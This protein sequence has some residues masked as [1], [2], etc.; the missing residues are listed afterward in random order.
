M[1]QWPVRQASQ[2]VNP[3][4]PSTK[5]TLR[6]RP[7]APPYKPILK[8][9]FSPQSGG[10]AS[11]EEGS[12]GKR[13]DKRFVEMSWCFFFRS[14]FGGAMALILTAFAAKGI[15]TQVAAIRS[16]WA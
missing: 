7:F 5:L 13:I 2:G 4:H 1:R 15:A 3:Q 14:L 16:L 9:R 12:L 11:A 6:I 10:C 8:G